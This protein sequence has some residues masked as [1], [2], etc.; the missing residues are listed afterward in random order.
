M[1]VLVTGG[2]SGLGLAMASALARAGAMVALTG[3]SGPR[4]SSVA[5]ELP[6][7]VG[8]ELDVLDE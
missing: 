5:A 6:A 4:A 7:A 3:R 1:N 2:T 8:V